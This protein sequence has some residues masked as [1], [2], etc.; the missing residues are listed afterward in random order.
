MHISTTNCGIIQEN[1]KGIVERVTFHNSDNGWS[2]LR[3]MPF[4]DPGRQETVVVHQT[5]VFAGATMEF[6]GSWTVHKKYGRQFHA[7]RAEEKK[8]A[9]SAALEKYLGSGLIKGVGP[10]TARK[11]VKHFDK[12]TLDVFEEEI[13]RLTEVP[14]IAMKKLEMISEAWNE[15]KSIRDVMMFLQSHGI[16]TLFAVRIYKEYGDNAISMVTED[17][18]RLA[19]DFYGIGFFSAD[20][21]A[22]SIGLAPDSEQRMIAAIRHVLAGARNFG[23]CYLTFPQINEEVSSLLNLGLEPDY[24]AQRLNEVLEQMKSS[25]KLMVRMVE[26]EVCYY[27]RSLYFDELYVASRVLSMCSGDPPDVEKNRIERWVSLYCKAKD[28]ALSDEQKRAV[29]AIASENFSVLTGGPGCGKTTTTLVIVKLIEAMSNTMPPSKELKILLAAPTGRATQRMS[30]VIGREAKTIHRLLEWQNGK[31]KKNEHNP[32]KAGFL[33][34][35]E[36]SMLDI[37]LTASLLK[38]VPDGCQVLF[39]GDADQLPSVGAGNVLKDIIAS[40]VVPCFTLT[41]IF[42]QAKASHIIRY[43]HEINSGNMPW[44][45]SPFNEPHLWQNGVD[46]MFMDSDEATM[47]QMK[48]INRIKNECIERHSET[49]GEKEDDD[50]QCYEFNISETIRPYE[51]EINIPKKFRHVDLNTLLSAGTRVEELVSVVKK[52]HP[53]SS[54]HYGYSALDVVRML[55]QEWIPKYYGKDCEIQILSPMTRGSLG[56]VNLNR[57]IQEACNPPGEGRRQIKVGERIFRVG[58]RVIHR[59]NNYDLGVFNGDIGNIIDMDNMELTC[60]V[61]FFPDN[62]VVN[63]SK[64]DIMEL[65]LAYA[66]TIHKSQGSEFEAVII[67]VLTQHFK[68]LYR[69]LIYTGL[70]RARKLAVFVGTRKAMAMAVKNQDTSLRQTALREL[71][72]KSARIS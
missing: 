12:N 66:V 29:I 69:N 56:T 32:L 17:P 20:R 68:M 23:H 15:H 9:S 59:R 1:L 21:V 63:Y 55:Y 11:I 33:I 18:Y 61:K 5:K 40:G 60:S 14:G 34:V 72:I 48:F 8:P 52:V 53:W 44:I 4:S 42:R 19:N 22:L 46:C 25:K 35:D 54:L 28:I 49:K 39:I 16:S 13:E 58:D 37:S 41:Q 62:K 3:V 67:P 70:T 51:T 71:L 65:D 2:I 10:K 57:V 30:E 43:A 64:D 6:Y 7:T 50:S 38:A 24:M 36:C 27:S 47:E 31:F 26:Q 45:G